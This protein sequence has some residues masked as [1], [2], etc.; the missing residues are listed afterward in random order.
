[1]RF[2]R[3]A[4]VRRILLSLLPVFLIAGPD[5]IKQEVEDDK[6]VIHAP[7]F[8]AKLTCAIKE[9]QIKYR[10]DVVSVSVLTI[11]NRIYSNSYISKI[12]VDPFSVDLL[13]YPS[14]GPPRLIAIM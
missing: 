7:Q 10:F 3:S 12:L 4:W 11:L 9:P 13:T 1:M 5:F 2:F 8:F 6:L 14:R